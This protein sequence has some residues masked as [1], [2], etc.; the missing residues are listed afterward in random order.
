MSIRLYN[1]N[2]ENDTDTNTVN[3]TQPN[4]EYLIKNKANRDILVSEIKSPIIQI[5]CYHVTSKSAKY[6]F[7]QIM[8]EKQIF[9]QGVTREQFSLPTI[10]MANIDTNLSLY[11]LNK[12]KRNLQELGCD[13]SVLSDEAF[14]GVF[15][16]YNCS[17]FL[18]DI[19]AVD[20]FR[21]SNTKL[22]NTWFA[23]P[24]EIMNTQSICNIPIDSNLNRMFL[25]RP[26]LGILHKIDTDSNFLFQDVYILPDA[27]Y[28]GSHFK[29]VEFNS[30]FG[31]PRKQV[32]SS[33]GEYFYFYRIFED[34][35]REGGWDINISETNEPNSLTDNEYGRYIRGGINRYA[36]F[37]E[38][39][40]THI[41]KTNRFSLTDDIIN[42]FLGAKNT[43]VI[44]YENEELDTILPDL[45]VKEYESFLP[46]S[47]HML[48]KSIL[49]DKYEI[50]NQD[51][52]SVL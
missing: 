22:N 32:Y 8:L 21:I 16:E 2:M 33:C 51:K 24:T 48:N 50:D 15:Y 12:I 28:S 27:V 3:I 6:P 25:S 17:M 52:Y 18:V 13:P 5:L 7:I 43:I 38:N 14:L 47:Y 34:A 20:I 29:Q 23:L 4:Y 30:V 41:E 46:I 9:L 19:S 40:A 36:L 39:Y 35:V 37:A 10:H 42:G 26:E 1:T 44:Q 31:V 45:L 49:G 11:V